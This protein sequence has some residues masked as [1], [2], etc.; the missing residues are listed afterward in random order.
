MI[1]ARVTGTVVPSKSAADI[2]GAV[3]RVVEVCD[4]HGKKKNN[5][6]IALDLVDSRNE[7]LVMLCRGS[8]V[9]WTKQTAD[10]PVDALIVALVDIIDEAG[11]IT[12]RR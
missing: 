7:D 3:W 1:L 5:R 9:R 12:Y 4:H 10:K 8:S 2:P 6:L 11:K